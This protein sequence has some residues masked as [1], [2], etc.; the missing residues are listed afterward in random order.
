MKRCFVC[1]VEKPIDEFH[2]HKQMKDG[3]LNKCKVCTRAYIKQH[4]QEN[5]EAVLASHRISSRKSYIKH[6]AQKQAWRKKYYQD[7]PD[8][9]QER[10]IQARAYTKANR[11]AKTADTIRYRA[12]KRAATGT[13]TNKQIADRVAYY[14]WK[15]WLCA[16]PW[17]E[18][19]HVKPL[20][21]GGWGWP[22]N[23]RPICRS[24]NASKGAKWPY[25]KEIHAATYS[26][27][28]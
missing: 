9:Y 17:R 8:K 4:T 1:S 12:R 28:Y 20:S 23:L 22:S 2:A 13:A 5:Y 7:N 16:A 15:C 11:P 25:N 24:C 6:K 14:G 27:A 18:I 21:K 10:L 19:D 3:H 26:A